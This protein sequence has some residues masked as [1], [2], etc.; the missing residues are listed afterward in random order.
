MFK[1]RNISFANAIFRNYSTLESSKYLALNKL[2]KPLALL[3][4]ILFSYSD[5]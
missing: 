4:I 5:F 3:R 1:L 2:C